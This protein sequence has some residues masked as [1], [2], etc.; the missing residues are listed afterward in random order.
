MVR[1]AAALEERLGRPDPALR[2]PEEAVGPTL[3]LARVV[4][5]GT[6]RI[7]APLAAYVAGR[8]AAARAEEGERPA[9]A[10]LEAL[11][12]ARSILPP[13]D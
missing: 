9:A 3:D 1:F 11:E 12:V 8:Y 5:H 6:E 2:M 7:N 4:A 10:V 13:G